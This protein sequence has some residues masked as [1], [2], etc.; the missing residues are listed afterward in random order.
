MRSRL[1]V[2]ETT[3]AVPGR[4][5]LDGH[6]RAASVREAFGRLLQEWPWELYCT[7]TFAD[8]VGPV[9]AIHEIRQHLSLIE[10]GM[11]RRIGWMFGLEQEYGAD[12]PH[13]H[14]LVCGDRR[15]LDEI[16]LYKGKPHEWRGLR[17]EPYWLAWM[18]RNGA[19]RFEIPKGQPNV[20]FYCAKYSGK[21]GEIFVSDNIERF[22]S[23]GRG[24]VGADSA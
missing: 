1:D 8:P 23:P 14:G 21:R 19:G 18:D 16:V 4:V 5:R 20:S 11:G 24:C 3:A 22:R 7:W 6:K 15:L 2:P 12:R 10:W 13:G 17:I 9:K